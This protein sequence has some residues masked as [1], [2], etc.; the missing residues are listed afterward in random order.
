MRQPSLKRKMLPP[1]PLQPSPGA[2]VH[3]EPS[4]HHHHDEPRD[5][6]VQ[7]DVPDRHDRSDRRRYRDHVGEPGQHIVVGHQVVLRSRRGQ[8]PRRPRPLG[9]RL[10]S[11]ACPGSRRSRQR[12]SPGRS[13]S[14]RGRE[15]PVHPHE[16]DQEH[17]GRQQRA[18]SPAGSEARRDRDRLQTQ[19]EQRDRPPG[20]CI[21][22]KFRRLP[23]ATKP[24]TRATMTMIATSAMAS[25]RPCGGRR[26]PGGRIVAQVSG[27]SLR[28]IARESIMASSVTTATSVPTACRGRFT[29]R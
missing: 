6:R 11:P 4:H 15:P 7:Q 23:R 24:T 20:M 2:M 1:V 13:G 16:R 19:T 18:Y 22:S 29:V 12:S 27:A 10:R 26:A 28:W 21:G 5:P 8:R 14:R 25:T 3:F 17:V 9:S